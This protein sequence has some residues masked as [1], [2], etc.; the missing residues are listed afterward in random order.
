MPVRCQTVINL[1]DK[2]APKNLAEDWDNIGLHVGDPAREINGV[3]VALDVNLQVVA[4][5][6]SLGANMIVAHHPLMSKPIKNIRADL[7][8]GRL[9]TEIVQKDICVYCAHTNL[10]SAR[11]GVNQVLAEL[12]QLQEVEVLN[13]DKGEKL[14]KLVIFVPVSHAEEVREAMTG[15]GAG[16]IGNYSDCTFSIEGTGTFKGAEGCKPFIGQVGILEKANE[17]RIETVVPEKTLSRV[18]NAMLKAHPYEEVAYDVYALVNQ[19]ERLGLGRLGKL[20]KPKKLG[21]FM[22]MIKKELNVS[23]V[24]YSGN[25]GDYVQKVALCGGSGAGFIHK[26]VFAGVDLFVTGD[27]KYHEA[28]EVQAL[29]LAF[30]DAGHYATENPIVNKL[31]GFL[32][33]ALQAAGNSLPVYVSGTTADA[34]KY[35]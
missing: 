34:F 31:A 33:E 21:D 19:A 24:R 30:V 11:E 10:D 22:D 9:L 32:K 25:T 17:I 2:F 18:I 26:A 16:F 35:Y 14:Y 13:P 29:G 12:F 27:L 5:A 8:Q 6:V 28:Q 20:A 1:I 15:A 23:I 7:P 3:L 4:E